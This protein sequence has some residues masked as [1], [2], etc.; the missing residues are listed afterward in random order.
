MNFTLQPESVS[1]LIY[2]TEP[3]AWKSHLGPVGAAD[4]WINSNRI[5]ER[6]AWLTAEEASTHNEVLSKKGYTGPL[7]WYDLLY[8]RR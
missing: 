1:S 7:N 6:P 8:T 3:E 2:P 5:S 4:A